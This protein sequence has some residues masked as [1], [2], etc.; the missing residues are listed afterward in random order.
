MVISVARQSGTPT[1]V[2]WIKVK[3]PAGTMA[4]EP[5]TGLYKISPRIGLTGW[6]VRAA[7]WWCR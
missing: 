3:V 2:E 4:S 5:T 1:D 6:T 7:G